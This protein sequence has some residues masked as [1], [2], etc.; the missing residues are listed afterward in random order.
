M[1]CQMNRETTTMMTKQQCCLLFFSSVSL[2][3]V[4]VSMNGHD[5]VWENETET[6][7]LNLRNRK[8]I[9]IKWTHR[10]TTH[11]AILHCE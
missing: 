8:I 4:L 5:D 3:D 9:N 10:R 7:F 1:R 6:T 2:S 11:D